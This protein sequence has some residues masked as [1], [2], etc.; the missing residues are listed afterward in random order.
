MTFFVLQNLKYHFLKNFGNQT[1]LVIIDFLLYEQFFFFFFN[2]PQ[3]KVSRHAGLQ[4]LECKVMM[5]EIEFLNELSLL[6]AV[7]T[8]IFV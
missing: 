7:S 1:I 4:W 6:S 3:K 8:L 2:A 5:T